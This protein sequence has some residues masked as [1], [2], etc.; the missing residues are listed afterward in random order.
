MGVVPRV[1]NE[2]ESE[3]ENSSLDDEEAAL[4]AATSTKR[5][6]SIYNR[7]A[8]QEALEESAVPENLPW[9][10]MMIMSGETPT[11]VSNVEDDLERELAFYNQALGAA[12]AAISKMDSEGVAWQRPTDYYAEMVKSDDHMLKV[13]EQL[14]FE[15]NSIAEAAQRR[16]SRDAK[17]F[18]K[19]VMAEVRKERASS[20]KQAVDSMTKLR[21]QREKSGYEGEVD[22]E[23]H[24]AAS[25]GR[26]RGRGGGRDGGRSQG[27]GGRSEGRGGRGGG[28]GPP[29]KRV[30]K[31]AKYGFGGPKRA[32]KRN[33][34]ASAADMNDFRQS[35]NGG[36]GRGRG[37]G[38]GG[39]SGGRGGGRGAGG[40]QS[41]RVSKGG[42]SN[43]PGKARREASRG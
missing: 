2:S 34:A 40:V 5:R 9:D 26:G 6:P 25:E 4:E 36:R 31:D 29:A 3:S 19:Q 38:R 41:G 16:K 35:S 21:K 43:R 33:D 1:T 37:G 28:R 14:V 12:R 39:R 22:V 8:L 32:G 10:E 17:K 23:A 7:D 27:R 30:A 42:A 11:I 18:G 20:K 13:R 24:L 15:Q